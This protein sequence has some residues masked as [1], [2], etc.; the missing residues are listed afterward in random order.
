MTRR[1]FTKSQ[2]G[3]MIRRASDPKGRIL[4]EGCGMD[5]TGKPFEFDHTTPEALVLDKSR[6]LT[7]DDGRLLGLC[8]HRGQHGKTAADVSRIAKAKR[9]E[10][11]RAPRDKSNGFRPPARRGRASAPLTKQLPPRRLGQ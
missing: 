6:P 5:V 8:C 10:Q 2:R 9:Q 1:E 11:M 7:I 4:C 3:Q